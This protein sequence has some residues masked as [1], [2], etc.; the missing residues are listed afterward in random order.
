AA[1]YPQSELWTGAEASADRVKEALASKDFVHIAAHALVNERD[2]S[3]S[4]IVLAPSS[5]NSGL[6]YVYQIMNL[7]LRAS[8]VTLIGC[9]TASNGETHGSVRSLALAFVAAGARSVLATLWNI[10]DEAAGRAAVAFHK[11]LQAGASPAVALQQM[12][13]TLLRSAHPEDRNYKNWAAFQI[14]GTGL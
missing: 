8:L 6:L 11:A 12:Q 13:L 3:H 4:S 1:A 2:P 10:D 14:Y 9:R 5:G 7:R